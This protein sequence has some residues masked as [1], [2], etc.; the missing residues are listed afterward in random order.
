MQQINDDEEIVIPK[1]E[2]FLKSC[3]ELSDYINKTLNLEHKV[4]DEFIQKL[5][6]HTT[7]TREEAFKSGI[8][9]ALGLAQIQE[10]IKFK[11]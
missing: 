3:K 11:N 7:I 6:K 9:F 2:R 4:N 8:A 1:T 10:E 5:L